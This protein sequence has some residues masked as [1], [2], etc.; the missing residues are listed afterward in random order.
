[1][2]DSRFPK[3]SVLLRNL[4]S[5]IKDF[6]REDIY[7]YLR[8]RDDQ[9]F[10]K[11]T[12][13]LRGLFEDAFA[14]VK[15]ACADLPHPPDV[16]HIRYLV[17]RA[18]PRRSSAKANW[19]ADL[20]G[21]Q[22]VTQLR[23]RKQDRL[24]CI[25]LRESTAPWRRV[26][27]MHAL[28]DGIWLVEPC[29]EPEHLVTKLTELLESTP[30]GLATSLAAIGEPMT[31]EL[32]ALLLDPLLVLRTAGW[33]SRCEYR[34][35]RFGI[36]LLGLHNIV[37]VNQLTTSRDTILWSYMTR[38]GNIGW[39]DVLRKEWESLS[40]TTDSQRFAAICDPF[41]Q[42]SISEGSRGISEYTIDTRSGK[43][44]SV[45]WSSGTPPKLPPLL[46]LPSLLQREQTSKLL[47]FSDGLAADTVSDLDRRI[48]H[49]LT[50]WS[51]ACECAQ[52]LEWEFGFE[53]DDERPFMPDPDSLILYSTIVLETL[54][55]SK[56]DKQ[57][58]TVR[59]ADY[60]AGLLGRSPQDRYDL[61]RRMKRAYA[62]RSAFVHGGTERPGDY[63][64]T[65]MWL[66]TISTLALWETVKLQVSGSPFADWE[67][68]ETYIV[69][70]KYGGGDSTEV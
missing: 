15:L 3:L 20:I 5:G 59:V 21:D 65:A 26:P 50:M 68:Y 8:E 30:P 27:T 22:V 38:Y 18:L 69:K 52:Q 70:R 55:S 16:G 63:D 24:V 46:V 19:D 49:A 7:D 17:W 4:K 44:E 2:G 41:D 11:K 9:E 39:S 40:D 51:K 64:S 1:M 43:I 23:A 36:P 35:R 66:F 60:T 25:P 12:K 61:A 45:T 33:R 34:A 32:G 67:Q 14:E 42:V 54:F 58:L 48:R 53:L 62:Q 57:E 6:C 13:H 47:A 10:N 29:G 56:A 28:A 37:H 31:S